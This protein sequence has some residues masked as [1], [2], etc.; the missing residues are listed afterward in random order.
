MLNF[1]FNWDW[2]GLT[3]ENISKSLAETPVPAF[4]DKWLA[5]VEKE[6]TAIVSVATT[7]AVNSPAVVETPANV[8]PSAPAVQQVV[9]NTIQAVAPV[10]AP[11]IPANVLSDFSKFITKEVVKSPE[12]KAADTGETPPLEVFTE[13]AQDAI[14][15]AT[16]NKKF[17]STVVKDVKTE[18]APYY[19][20]NKGMM[21]NPDGTPYV[22]PKAAP[23]PAAAP[24]KPEDTGL[25]MGAGGDTKGKLGGPGAGLSMLSAIND[26]VV[27]QGG[28][29]ID[30]TGGLV[31]LKDSGP[32]KAML[33]VINDFVVGQGGAPIDTT[34][35]ITGPTI[36]GPT[37]TGPTI[38]GPTIT[39]P[40][41]TGP[42]ITGP[43]ITGPTITGPT[44][45]GPS[46]TGPT[47]TGPT[48]VTPGPTGPTGP[49]GPG[50]TGPVQ[51]YTAPDGKIFTDINEYNAYLQQLKLDE[52]KRLG[53]SAY[54]LLFDQFNQFGLGAL[55]TPLQNLIAEGLSQAEFTL[56][57]R[58]TDAYKKRFGAN[59]QRIAKGLR[60]LSEAEYIL[61][62]DKYQDVMR[63]YGLPESYYARGDMG[64]QEG[65]E[66][67][68][69]GDVSATELE[70]RIA[71]AQN[72]IIYANPEVGIALRTFY[73]D[74][75]N[76]DLLAYA[77][78][79]EKALAQIK[80]RISAAEIGASAV[81]MGLAS[82]VTDA[83][84]LARYGVTKEQAQQGYR[85]V[86]EV[87]PRAS[88]LGEIYAKQGMGLYTQQT[89]EREVF[90]V[91][92]AAEAA[93][94]RRK[95][96]ELEQAQFSGRAGTA[97][98]ALARERAGGF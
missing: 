11:S 94:Q 70:D 32:G 97:G 33:D 15:S 72:R 92:G 9:E 38:T 67:F 6:I 17:V 65:F 27:A 19:D 34:G 75:T 48:V 55:V 42:T 73:P 31:N 14:D 86:A 16:A 21:V 61:M 28:E 29:P 24:T 1:D 76:G 80:R 3:A 2:S 13:I 41:I 69:A 68:I 71:T 26:I 82:N 51:S 53:Q 25:V 58:D 35:G 62:E 96:T 60:A 7:A 66:K 36:T 37:I 63:R 89:A 90:N 64:R 98:G 88:M 74:I 39:G 43:T 84:Y 57:L 56:R 12:I 87:L 10:V 83:E 50:A 30:T 45:T 78:D 23:T 18:T 81:Q 49:T 79:P 22:P 20:I 59:Q 54:D 5:Q 46:L 4:D 85:S 95:L 40:T 44:I 91:P 47:I 77:L 52:K 93:A 8:A